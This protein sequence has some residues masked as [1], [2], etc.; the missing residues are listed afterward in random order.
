MFTVQNLHN[1][2]LDPAV[3]VFPSE[4]FPKII[5]FK[6]GD[7]PNGISDLKGTRADTLCHRRTP[8]RQLGIYKPKEF[9]LEHNLA[10]NFHQNCDKHINAD[11]YIQP[12]VLYYCIWNKPSQSWFY[13][14]ECV[15]SLGHGSTGNSI[16]R[17]VSIP[18]LR[19]LLEEAESRLPQA[20]LWLPGTTQILTK[21]KWKRNTRM[22]Y[23][24]VNVVFPNKTLICWTV[25]RT[26]TS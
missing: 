2:S 23:T 8:K 25:S 16:C 5:E 13:R 15:W 24:K 19:T 3:M 7:A 12:A 10:L 6:W 1:E 22:L 17:Q 9:S 14:K 20:A 11:Y 26:P 21:R 4:A 18:A